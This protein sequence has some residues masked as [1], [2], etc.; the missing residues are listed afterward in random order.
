M[1]TFAVRSAAMFRLEL[2]AGLLTYHL[3]GGLILRAAQHAHLRP[4]PL[5]FARCWRRIRDTLGS[6]V[7][8]WVWQTTD[9]H[10]YV[11]DRLA[12][13]SAPVPTLESRA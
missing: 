4:Q 10:T 6:G 7:P 1:D 5:S 9:P 3:I 8:D 2:A 13:G 12:R 11:L